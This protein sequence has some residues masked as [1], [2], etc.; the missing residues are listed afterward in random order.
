MML[1]QK[2]KQKNVRV[3][4]SGKASLLQRRPVS[5]SARKWNIFARENTV[6]GRPSRRSRSVCRKLGGPELSC[7]RRRKVRLQRAHVAKPN[8]IS[9]KGR[10]AEA[11]HLRERAHARSRKRSSV[12]AGPPLQK[13]RSP[14]KL[15]PPLENAP[16]PNARPLRRKL[17]GPERGDRIILLAKLFAF[18]TTNHATGNASS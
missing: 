5:L 6:R 11:K 13:G 9:R 18:R 8:A 7:R 2:K 4:T 3:R 1:C 10:S 12:K 15:A 16:A 14:S 17:L